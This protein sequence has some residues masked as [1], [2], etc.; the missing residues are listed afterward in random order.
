[1]SFVLSDGEE[2]FDEWFSSGHREEA[3][4]NNTSEFQAGATW[5]LGAALENGTSADSDEEDDDIE[6]EDAVDPGYDGTDPNIGGEIED[7]K[8]PA[9]D[10][11]KLKPVSVDLGKAPSNES[12]HRMDAARKKTRKRKRILRN[13]SLP[14]NL[15][16]LL[17]NLHRCH[18]LCL[19]SSVSHVSSQCSDEQILGLAGS[20]LPPRWALSASSSTPS[21]LELKCF[22]QEWYFPFVHGTPTRRRQRRQENAAM[23]AP[24]ARRRRRRS[25]P[26]ECQAPACSL[27][28]RLQ[29]YSSYLAWEMEENIQLLS[30]DDG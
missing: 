15:A 7:T 25:A 26:S 30:M 27:A 21:L 1:M 5:P 12:E 18:L 4:N 20:L 28:D 24:A 23:G 2:D 11:A 29:N 17:E 14:Q 19:A 3:S 22:L 9:I 6:W 10:M 16:S 13:K 8:Q